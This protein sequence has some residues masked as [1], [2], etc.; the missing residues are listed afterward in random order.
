MS[1]VAAGILLALI[2]LGAVVSALVVLPVAAQMQR[3]MDEKSARTDV[4]L[5]GTRRR[6]EALT[7]HRRRDVGPPVS[8]DA[9]SG[10]NRP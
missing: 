1:A 3:R 4:L 8:L 6:H 9:H 2:V 7:A 5:H 10:R